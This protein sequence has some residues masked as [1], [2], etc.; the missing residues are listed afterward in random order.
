MAKCFVRENVIKKMQTREQ[1]LKASW[2]YLKKASWKYLFTLKNK[3]VTKRLKR[4]KKLV[5]EK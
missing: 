1:F 3:K 2:K 4:K 5:P